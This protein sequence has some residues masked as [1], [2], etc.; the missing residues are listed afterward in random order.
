MLCDP[1]TQKTEAV[2]CHKYEVPGQP[3]LY[4]VFKASRRSERQRKKEREGKR[5]RERQRENIKIIPC[6]M[7]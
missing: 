4:W 5:E 2:G 1:N 7:I 3:R 6:E